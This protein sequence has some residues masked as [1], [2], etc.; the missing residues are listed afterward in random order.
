[1]FHALVTFTIL[2]LL[3][4]SFGALGCRFHTFTGQW[5]PCIRLLVYI[6]SPLCLKFIL[7][8]NLDSFATQFKHSMSHLRNNHKLLNQITSNLCIC[9]SPFFWDSFDPTSCW[10][11]LFLALVHMLIAGQTTDSLPFWIAR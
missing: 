11:K 10:Y 9:L 2:L 3:L 8:S 1:M 5:T 7:S 6:S 4:F